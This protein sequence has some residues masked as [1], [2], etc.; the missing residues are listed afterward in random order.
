MKAVAVNGVQRVVA[1]RTELTC[2]DI[3]CSNGQFHIDEHKI[4]AE[5]VERDACVDRRKERHR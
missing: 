2:E 5:T 1:M 3:Q 4:L